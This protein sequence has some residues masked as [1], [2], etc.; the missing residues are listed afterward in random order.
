MTPEAGTAIA[1]EAIEHLIH[2]DAS[3]SPS[4]VLTDVLKALRR[5]GVPYEELPSVLGTMVV[6]LV[7][8]NDRL[9]SGAVLCVASA[10]ML[11]D[12]YT[13]V[14]VTLRGAQRALTKCTEVLA[15]EDTP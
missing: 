14:K 5:S 13:P 8:L 10:M 1:R 4:E 6:A 12:P 11:H 9:A 7:H 2:R 3:R 15:E